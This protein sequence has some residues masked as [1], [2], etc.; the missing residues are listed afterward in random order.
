MFAALF[1][2]GGYYLANGLH[3]ATYKLALPATDLSTYPKVALPTITT[4]LSGAATAAT[5]AAN[6]VMADYPKPG[7][8]PGE[9]IREDFIVAPGYTAD[10]VR[11][12]LQAAGVKGLFTKDQIQKSNITS[13]PAA[14]SNSLGS[15]PNPSCLYGSARYACDDFNGNQG[16]SYLYNAIHWP[17][18]GH[19]HPQI[20]FTDQT[21]AAWPVDA[22]VYEWNKA[23]GIDSN[24]QRCPG[25]GYNCVTVVDKNYGNGGAWQGVQGKTLVG[26]TTGNWLI[27]GATSELNDY[28]SAGFNAAGHR[29]VACHELGHSLGMEHN[30][31][32]ASDSCMYS[33]NL[34][35]P[36]FENPSADDFNLL[37]YNYNGKTH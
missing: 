16:V 23:Q 25:S 20:Y 9:R 13:V 14:Q 8:A 33:A 12:S 4:N 1:T 34:N 36:A 15:Y 17:N 3:A 31:T 24:Y 30:V 6:D 28:K 11:A 37:A 5:D 19:S 32:T 22:A 18:R 27:T 21:G 29:E 2:A 10:Q 7:G 26:Y 35:N